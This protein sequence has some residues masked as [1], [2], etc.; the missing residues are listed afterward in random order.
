[1]VPWQGGGEMIDTVTLEG[2]SPTRAFCVLQSKKK[3]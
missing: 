2:A 1:M 3:R